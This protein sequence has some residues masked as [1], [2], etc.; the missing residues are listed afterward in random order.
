VNPNPS[1]LGA[2]AQIT[3]SVACQS[4]CGAGNWSIDGAYQGGFGLGDSG[5]SSGY[6]GSSLGVGTHTITVRY[7]GN[8]VPLSFEVVNPAVPIVPVVMS[9][10]PD[11][12][13]AGQSVTVTSSVGYSSGSGAG[14]W[15][16]DGAY[17]GG[18]G[19]TGNVSQRFA[20]GSNLSVG[21]HTVTVNYSGT[22]EYGPSLGSITFNVQ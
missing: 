11:P 10:A 18:F 5:T 1:R 3:I 2:A 7:G 14:N 17:M 4:A 20:L 6:F 12:I 22:A 21:T 19:Y 15:S 9:V 16:L 8:S 13:T